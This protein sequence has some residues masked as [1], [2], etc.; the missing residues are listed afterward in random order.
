MSRRLQPAAS[1]S[2]IS[3]AS[4]SDGGSCARPAAHAVQPRPEPPRGEDLLLHQAGRLVP[5][6]AQP[7]LGPVQRERGPAGHVRAEV[8]RVL[9]AG[10]LGPASAQRAD[11][12]GLAD[13]D[14][15]PARL[16]GQD[17][18]LLPFAGPVRVAAGQHVGQPGR[19]PARVLLGQPGHPDRH[20]G[21]VVAAVQDLGGQRRSRAARRSE[22]DQGL[23]RAAGRGDPLPDQP[24]L[25]R[26][27][28]LDQQ[29]RPGAQHRGQLATL[30]HDPAPYRPSSVAG[31]SPSSSR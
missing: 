11:R 18:L 5:G 23:R 22:A 9:P 4:S 14:P 1:S 30:A 2:R 16:A 12:G 20:Q 10:G 31:Q 27:A 24:R 26:R 25:G 19:P 13:Q 21:G 3:P 8:V 29:H 7:V 15:G 6:A 17:P 28:R